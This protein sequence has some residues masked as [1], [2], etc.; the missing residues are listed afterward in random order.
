MS[1]KKKLKEDF[2]RYNQQCLAEVDAWNRA[3]DDDLTIEDARDKGGIL[4]HPSFDEYMDWKY[5]E[6]VAARR[7]RAAQAEMRQRFASLPL[8]DR[9]RV[10]ALHEVIALLK[11]H[12]A[13]L[14]ELERALEIEMEMEEGLGA[15][16]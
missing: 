13:N 6:R 14:E 15:F 16:G 4:T 10:T 11:Q 3:N 12:A 2:V 1:D 8:R 7:R 9:L 5:P